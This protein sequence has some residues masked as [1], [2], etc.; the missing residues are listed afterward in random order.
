MRFRFEIWITQMN[1]KMILQYK[2]WTN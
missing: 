2:R 1:G